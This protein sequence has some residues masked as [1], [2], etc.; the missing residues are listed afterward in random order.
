M[1]LG[2]VLWNGRRWIATAVFLF[3]TGVLLGFWAAVSQPDVFLEQVRPAMERIASIGTMVFA[4]P[5]PL[6]RT[7]IIYRNNAQAMTIMTIGGLFLGLVPVMAVFG[8]GALIG[9]F[10]GLSGEI[11]PQANDPWR[12]FIALAPHGV[13]ELP[14]VWLAAAW[15][16]KLGLAYLSPAAAGRRWG[17]FQESVRETVFVLFIVMI[18]LAIAAAI[19]GNVTLALVQGM[20]A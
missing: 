15:A 10:L 17:A 13:I 20:R 19:E 4:S 14:A 8:N 1:K 5:S 11:A 3:V 7:W 16:M 12:L 6:E 9:V 2:Y 18:M